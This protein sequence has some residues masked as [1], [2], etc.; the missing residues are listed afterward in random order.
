MLVVTLTPTGSSTVLALGG[1]TTYN[2]QW[3]DVNTN[4]IFTDTK[5]QTFVAGFT[6]HW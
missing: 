2:Y 5:L 4:I 1:N 3:T 6:K